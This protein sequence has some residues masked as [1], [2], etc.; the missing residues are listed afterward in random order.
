MLVG[1]DAMGVQLV[2]VCDNRGWSVEG[3]HGKQL[4]FS[5]VLPFLF[6]NVEVLQ[7]TTSCRL[8]ASRCFINGI[9][10]PAAQAEHVRFAVDVSGVLIDSPAEHSVWA[11]HAASRCATAVWNSSAP[12]ESHV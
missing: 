8:Q 10:L 3:G 6:I 5:V 9:H 11:W 2:S 7:A 4:C 1:I 12:H